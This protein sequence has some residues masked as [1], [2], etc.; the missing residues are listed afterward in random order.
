MSEG[1]DVDWRDPNST[2]Y[3]MWSAKAWG[4]DWLDWLVIAHEQVGADAVFSVQFKPLRAKA[5]SGT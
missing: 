1:W 4:A 2:H 3:V 5:H